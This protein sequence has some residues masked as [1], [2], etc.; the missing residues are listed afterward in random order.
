MNTNISIRGARENN[1]QNISLDIPLNQFVVITGVSGSGKSSLAFDTIRAEGQRRYLSSLSSY[2][3][4]FLGGMR[5]PDVDSIEGLPPTLSIEAAKLH[6]N[7]RS[8]V[9][10][11]TEIYDYLRL[12]FARIGTAHC[13]VCG[14]EVIPR[15]ANQITQ[16]LLSLA[17]GTKIEI[18]APAVTGK[19]G[20]HTE[21]LDEL[22]KK[23]YLR[24]VI[25]G[26]PTTLDQ[27]ISLPSGKPHTI[28]VVID[29]IAVSP[30]NQSR[31][32]ESAEAA[33]NFGEGVMT[34]EI[35]GKERKLFSNRM[36]C[37]VCNISVPKLDAKDF[38]FNNP[39]G[40]CSACSGLGYKM[41]MSESLV[42]P[43]PDLSLEEG[44]LAATGFLSGGKRITRLMEDLK[45]YYGLDTSMPVRQYPERL[46]DIL[47][48]GT[49]YCMEKYQET[50]DQYPMKYE[51]MLNHLERRYQETGSDALRD[52][53]ET[54][55]IPSPCH[56]CGGRRLKPEALAVTVGGK[57]IFQLT[58]MSIGELHRFFHDLPLSDAEKDLVSQLLFEIEGRL[59]YLE[60]VGLSYLS[61]SRTASSLSGGEYQ[62]VRLANQIG[63]GVVGVVYILDE[64][65]VGLHQKD[66]DRLLSML[67]QLRDAGNSVLVVEHDEDTI[68]SADWLIDMGPGAGEHGGKVVAQG[69]LEELCKCKESLTAAYLRKEKEIPVPSHRRRPTGYLGLYGAAKHNLKNLDVQIPLG[70]F[71]CVTGVSGSGKST[72]VND[73]LYAELSRRYAG[74]KAEPASEGELVR[75]E[76]SELLDKVIWVDQNPIG[77]SPRSNPATYIGLFDNIRELFAETKEA[78]IRGYDK[79]RFS[80]NVP[81]GRCEACKGEGLVKMDMLFLPDTYT[82]CETCGGKRYNQE[83][84]QIRYKGKNISEVLEMTFEEAQTFFEQIPSMKRK[85][86]AMNDVGLGYL[87]LGQQATTLSGGEAQR[88][89][90]AN[91]LSRPDTGRT[92][93]L[94]DE[95]TTGLHFADIH[96]LIEVLQRLVQAGNSVL[97]IEHNM[98]VIKSADWLIDLGPEGGDSGGSLVAEGTPEQ[99]SA[100][101]G[102]YTGYYLKQYLGETGSTIDY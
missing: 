26:I 41:K 19:K 35:E 44:A 102:S 51:G 11:L 54:F 61:L 29:R 81:G 95:P 16:E 24:V 8:T 12:L 31:L 37:P 75:L 30:K 18:I 76:G 63:S 98:D 27:N 73:I 14:R 92:L 6:S 22:K 5:K 9:G 1:L 59:S 3:K 86:Q 43:D 101:A 42:I 64:P 68:R 13:P 67:L 100:V 57:N 48:Y 71:C 33:L 2:A 82:A 21:L 36:Y 65:S 52:T 87:R 55:M 50:E 66:N 17:E 53:Y 80:F 15:A 49:D 89:K 90:L 83:T 78:R 34:V 7:P 46:H 39:Y 97:V 28:E 47:L 56:V 23:G 85:L 32:A 58:Q 79:G 62:R 94:L 74:A 84:L 38:S 60:K 93:Y 96:R 77:R 88:L 72:L 45:K 25:D 40:A 69:S 91:E 10:T 20:K 99:V 4:Q 70:V